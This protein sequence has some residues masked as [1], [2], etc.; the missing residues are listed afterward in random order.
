MEQGRKAL[1]QEYNYDHISFQEPK[2]KLSLLRGL[3]EP[4][5]GFIMKRFDLCL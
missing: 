1:H 3:L 4:V 2:Y 5:I